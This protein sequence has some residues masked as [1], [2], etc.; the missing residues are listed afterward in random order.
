MGPFPTLN[1][2]KFILVI[3]DYVSKW[4]ED[5]ASLTNDAQVVIKVFKNV[6]FPRFGTPILVISDG[7]SHFISKCFENLLTN[8]IV[9]YIV[10]IPFHPQTRR[11]EEISNREIK[12]ILEKMV[13]TTKKGLVY[14]V[15]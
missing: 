8:Y 11:H 4:I 3:V 10:A 15:K 2:Y 12:R 13:S 6:I 9:K 5:I 1:G 14:K 7:G